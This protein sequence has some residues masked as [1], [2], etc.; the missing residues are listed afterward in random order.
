MKVL[1]KLFSTESKAQD[2]SVIPKR[3]CDE[4]LNSEDYKLIIQNK[5]SLGGV[6]HKD[7]DPEKYSGSVGPDDQILINDNITHY[8][9]KCF[10]KEGDPNLYAFIETFNPENFSGLRRDNIQNLIGLL[11]EGV[12][13][14]VSVVIHALW[15]TKEVAEKIIRI[16]GVDFTM[17]PSFS[18]AGTIK[19]MSSL[20]TLEENRSFSG[21][22]NSEINSE[23]KSI[24]K[25]FSAQVVIVDNELPIPTQ[26][27]GCDENPIYTRSQVIQKYGLNSKQAE[28]TKTYSLISKTELESLVE[29]IQAQ[30]DQISKNI[31]N[32]K[33][34][35]DLI[36]DD[37]ESGTDLEVIESILISSK[38]RLLKFM[39][40]VD[41]SN[42]A[43]YRSE[44]K[45]E[46]HKILRLNPETATFSTINSVRDR[47][48]LDRY[49]RYS[50][51]NRLIKSYKNYPKKLNEE[52]SA[53]IK[54][55][56]IQD[57]NL[58]IKKVEPNIIKGSTLQ[59]LYALTQFSPEISKQGVKLSQIYRQMLIAEKV[60]G[61]VP[62]TK[63]EKWIQEKLKFYNLFSE[64]VFGSGLKNDFTI[65]DKLT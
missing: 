57:L 51:I 35:L 63:Y 33:D 50:L 48:I 23:L 8:I 44:M 3:S 6:T 61:F 43:D 4:Y 13:L 34:L 45:S 56:F 11:K 2:G 38:P 64:Y 54:D 29:P 47:L 24:T 31:I 58:L 14:P 22:E 27:P 5:L 52:D 46:I 16:K 25:I 12:N 53:F 1:L 42:L 40:E 59:S 37:L 17:N 55:L 21:N 60:L 26:G 32:I 62:R 65:V 30:S 39:K 10:F 9:T 20:P 41:Q 18:G 7:R 49:P 36:K 15:S 28:V 19:L